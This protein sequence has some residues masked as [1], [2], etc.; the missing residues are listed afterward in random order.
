MNQLCRQSTS[1]GAEE[2][3]II[4]RI[5]NQ[6]EALRAFGGHGEHAAILE[7]F[8]AVGPIVVHGE[9]GKFMVVQSG[10]HQLLIIQQESERFYKM[11]PGARIGTE[12]DDIAGVGRD[13][14]LIE[15]DV[16]H[17]GNGV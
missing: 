14:R 16:E 17:A 1:F 7:A 9:R 3:D 10:S 4:R 2:K 11:Q 6:I 12:T 15:N 5:L 8:R 13:F